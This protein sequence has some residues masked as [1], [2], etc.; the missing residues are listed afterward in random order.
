MY[1]ESPDH[2]TGTSGAS[3]KVSWTA[4]PPASGTTYTSALPWM[5]ELNASHLPSGETSGESC[6]PG[7]VITAAACPPPAGTR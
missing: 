1:C 2:D 6:T 5:S 4:C 7:I 3:W